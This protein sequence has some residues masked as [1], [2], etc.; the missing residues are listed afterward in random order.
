M[1]CLLNHVF[2]GVSFEN[3]RAS[4]RLL[5][6]GKLAARASRATIQTARKADNSGENATHN[7]ACFRAREAKNAVLTQG[8]RIEIRTRNHAV[9]TSN[10]AVSDQT[11]AGNAF[12]HFV[13]MHALRFL[14]MTV[15]FFTMMIVVM[16]VVV[17]RMAQTLW[18]TAENRVHRFANQLQ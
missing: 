7:M 11:A 10:R 17:P 6:L 12:H 18:N 1:V 4:V 9:N 2:C 8:I 14:V 13:L 5:L 3:C 16:A 15:S